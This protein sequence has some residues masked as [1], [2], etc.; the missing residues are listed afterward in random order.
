[1]IKTSDAVT[2]MSGLVRAADAG[3]GQVAVYRP[4][5]PVTVIPVESVGNWPALAS[6]LDGFVTGCVGNRRRP[7]GR[8]VSFGLGEEARPVISIRVGRS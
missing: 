5:D 8:Q 1:M 4:S 3:L 6:I 7:L 2:L